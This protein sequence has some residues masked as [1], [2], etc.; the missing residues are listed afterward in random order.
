MIF[1]TV[2]TQDVPFD[3]LLKAVEKQIKNGN[4]KEEVIVQCGKTK[5]K[6]KNMKFINFLELE[7]F[8]KL[9]KKANL[10]I[11]H[12][13]VGSILDGLKNNKVVIACPRLAKYKEHNNDHQ[14]EIINKFSNDGY[15]IPLK[16]PNKLDIALEQALIFR[17]KKYKS[18]TNNMIKIIEDFIDNN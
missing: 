18:N 5:F 11:C 7:E 2:G 9:I 1:V 12:G 3:R 8:N 16:D 4:I 17:P 13:G 14:L 10:I 15:I 6:S